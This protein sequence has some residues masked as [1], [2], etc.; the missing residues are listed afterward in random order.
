MNDGIKQADIEMKR[1]GGYIDDIG[2]YP[3]DPRFRSWLDFLLFTPQRMKVI[4]IS[5]N[6]PDE[7]NV[8]EILSSSGV[9]SIGYVGWVLQEE[10]NEPDVDD[11]A[12][13]G[14]DNSDA[15]VKPPIPK[16]IA[17]VASS[18]LERLSMFEI[19]SLLCFAAVASQDMNKFNK[20][21]GLRKL[22]LYGD[23]L[24]DEHLKLLHPSKS[25]MILGL[26]LESV[27]HEGVMELMDRMP[28]PTILR[29]G[30]W[31][32]YTVRL[33]DYKKSPEKYGVN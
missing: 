32:P 25:L 14:T 1:R 28:D 13:I 33:E 29:L 17:Y 9:R 10:Y 20:I 11:S 8:L 15:N 22:E 24:T 26:N 12:E 27:S 3:I 4:T 6:H 18:S 16:K 2:A 5:L 31:N 21:Q 23:G 19:E 7:D 30:S